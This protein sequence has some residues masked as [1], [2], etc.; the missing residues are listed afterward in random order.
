MSNDDAND[1][2]NFSLS[3]DRHKKTEASASVF[4]LKN[5]NYFSTNARSIT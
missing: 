5:K 2:A 3:I 1:T 4:E